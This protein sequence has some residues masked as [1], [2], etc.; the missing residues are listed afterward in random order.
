MVDGRRIPYSAR[1]TGG[2]VDS[3]LNVGSA[4]IAR[5]GTKVPT[6]PGVA[7]DDIYGRLSGDRGWI[8]FNG[9]VTGS[10]TGAGIFAVPA[11]SPSALAL[12]A[13]GLLAAASR[14]PRRRPQR[15]S[16]QA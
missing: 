9:T 14:A 12:T 1:V 13:F 10:Q 3:V 7:I 6:L 5:D 15:F 8:A 16:M 11:L 2:S 4:T